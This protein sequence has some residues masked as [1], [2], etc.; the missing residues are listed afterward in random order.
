MK[1]GKVRTKSIMLLQLLLYKP[2]YSKTSLK[3]HTETQTSKY[4]KATYL[5]FTLWFNLLLRPLDYKE[6]LS[7]DP[8][9]VLLLRFYCRSFNYVVSKITHS[10]RFEILW[11]RKMKKNKNYKFIKDQQ[12]MHKEIHTLKP[13]NTKS[14]YEIIHI[15]IHWHLVCDRLLF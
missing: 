11:Q 8:M 14:T 3:D 5:R 1:L 15:V 12:I 2:A 13:F 4:F 9:V 7:S 10:A 6:H